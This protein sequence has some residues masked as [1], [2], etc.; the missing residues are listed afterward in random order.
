MWNLNLPGCPHAILDQM[1]TTPNMAMGKK[2]LNPEA[3]RA[4]YHP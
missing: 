3:H 1:D 2:G 4:A